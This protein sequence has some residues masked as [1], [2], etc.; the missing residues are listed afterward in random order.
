M[1]SA[2]E[3]P[4]WADEVV[5]MF[6]GNAP[7]DP[8]ALKTVVKR[9]SG[10]WHY[11]FVPDVE[12]GVRT[13]AG[14]QAPEVLKSVLHITIWH[15]LFGAG[16]V[17]ALTEGTKRCA[18]I[19]SKAF[20]LLEQLDALL[21][22]HAR[23]GYEGADQNNPP[24][25]GEVF[26]AV[27]RTEPHWAGATDIRATMAAIRNTSQQAPTFLDFIEKTRSLW[28]HENIA[29]WPERGDRRTAIAH[30]ILDELEQFNWL[31]HRAKATLINIATDST[32]HTPDSLKVL[33]SRRRKAGG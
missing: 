28:T 11:E 29:Y 17:D 31:T 22:E 24:N 7:T 14:S 2:V 19:E 12:E 4:S 10:R 3:L 20:D 21:R 6:A 8:E 1:S 26:E 27:I 5:A 13:H 16:D 15:A 18:V 30:K 33:T 9:L 32:E 25:F 23:L